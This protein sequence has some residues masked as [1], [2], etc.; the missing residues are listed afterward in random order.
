[1]ALMSGKAYKDSLSDLKIKAYAFGERIDNLLDHELTGPSIEAVALAYDLALQPETQERMTTISP[2][3]GER[4]S[5]LTHV[6]QS[7]DDLIGVL[8]RIKCYALV[9]EEPDLPCA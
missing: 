1:M 5:R 4:V 7:A 9:P 6:Y 8:E 2:L 3:T